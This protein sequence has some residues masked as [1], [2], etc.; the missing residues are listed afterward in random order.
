MH[1]KMWTEQ[2]RTEQ[3]KRNKCIAAR[4]FYYNEW[5]KRSKLKSKANKFDIIF[6][7]SSF[8]WTLS[9]RASD[10]IEWSGLE[11][12]MRFLV[13]LLSFVWIPFRYVF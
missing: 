12:I 6:A 11:T 1:H 9:P 5:I 8:L 4:D 13:L 3:T 10:E 7:S 2:N